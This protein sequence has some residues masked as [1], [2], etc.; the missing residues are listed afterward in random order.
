MIPKFKF[1]RHVDNKVF[2]VWRL[3]K[4]MNENWMVEVKGSSI[5]MWIDGKHKEGDLID[6]NAK[7]D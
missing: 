7:G 3:T 5:P 4:Y 1:R 2:D 6:C